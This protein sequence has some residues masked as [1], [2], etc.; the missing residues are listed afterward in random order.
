MYTITALVTPGAPPRALFARGA[1]MASNLGLPCLTVLLSGPDSAGTLEALPQIK[2]LHRGDPTAMP[3]ASL[4]SVEENLAALGIDLAALAPAARLRAINVHLA[5]ADSGAAASPDSAFGGGGGG[6]GTGGGSGGGGSSGGGGGG[7]A[8]HSA[9][10]LQA[11]RIVC[12]KPPA[13]NALALLGGSPDCL[14]VAYVV[15]C[16]GDL[17]IYKAYRSNANAMGK[18][19]STAPPSPASSPGAT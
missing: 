16:I 7:G 18:L 4:Q 11:I 15:A 12:T 6:S 10:T 13:L 14:T 9:Q 19:S 17:K 3:T 5:V 1:V 2:A 8:S